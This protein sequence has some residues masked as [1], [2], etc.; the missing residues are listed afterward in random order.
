[1][2]EL[3]PER[4]N[5]IVSVS[6]YLIGSPEA[7]KRPTACKGRARPV[8]PVVLRY[9]ARPHRVQTARRDR[10]L[11]MLDMTEV[12]RPSELFAVR[13]RSFDNLNPLSITETV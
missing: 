1:M 9:G 4:C 12:L 13:W 3:R 5:A 10:I 8:V 7:N 6:G 2:S 11:F